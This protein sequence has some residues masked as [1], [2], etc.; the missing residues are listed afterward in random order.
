M[1]FFCISVL[2]EREPH[3]L[4]FIDMSHAFFSP[5]ENWRKKGVLDKYKGQ[6]DGQSHDQ[7]PA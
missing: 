2:K 1:L 3:V 4:T 7:L 6:T 5:K